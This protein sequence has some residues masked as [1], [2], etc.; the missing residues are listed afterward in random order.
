MNDDLTDERNDALFALRRLLCAVNCTRRETLQGTAWETRFDRNA[1]P[2][3]IAEGRAVIERLAVA[4]AVRESERGY[5][6]GL[7]EE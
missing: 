1:L 2:S 5:D 4:D 6:M 7:G 3:A